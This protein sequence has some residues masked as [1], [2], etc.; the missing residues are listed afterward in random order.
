VTLGIFLVSEIAHCKSCGCN[1]HREDNEKWKKLCFECWKKQKNNTASGIIENRLVAENKKLIDD[2]NQLV[3]EY[4]NLLNEYGRFKSTNNNQLS[5]EL[6]SKLIRL[7][8]PDKHGNS[9]TSNDVTKLLLS[10]RKK[11]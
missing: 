11:P 8:H 1:F 5:Q 3:N 10:M 7:C 9:D 6:I 2:Y 4:N